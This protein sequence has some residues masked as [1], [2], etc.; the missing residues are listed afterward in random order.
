MRTDQYIAQT[1]V[2]G[3]GVT[4]GVIS[5][6]VTSL[7]LITSRAELPAVQIVPPSMSPQPHPTVTDEGTMMLEEVYAIAPGAS[8]L[9]C[10]P[11]TA[12]E[13]IQCVQQLTLAGRSFQTMW[14]TLLLTS[15]PRTMRIL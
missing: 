13:Y 8:L 9:F 14:L 12:N 4:I 1:N 10:G 3:S 11:E 6:D 15:W 7:T 5:D 2:N